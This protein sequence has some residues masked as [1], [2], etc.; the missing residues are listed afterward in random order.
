MVEFKNDKNMKTKIEYLVPLFAISLLP[1]GCRES[2]EEVDDVRFDVSTA[3]ATFKAGEPVRFSFRGNP[4]FIWFYSGERG[5]EYAFKEQDRIVETRMTFSFTTT[6]ASGTKGYPNPARV[7]ISYSTDFSGEYTEEAVREAT[8]IDITDRFDMPTDIGATDLLSGEVNISDFYPDNDTPLYLSFHYV[9]EAYDATAAGGN[10]NGRT[11][12]NF[13]SPKINGI[14]GE[15]SA[16]LYDI[17]SSNWTIVRAA[18][19]EGATSLPDIN[20]SRILLRSEFQP[21]VSRECWAVA[22][23]IHKMDYINEGPDM[24]VGIKAMAEAALTGYSYVYTEPGEYTA[25]FVAANSNVY[26]RRE[27]VR[28]VKIRIVEDEGSIT[29]PEAGE[30]NE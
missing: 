1:C 26:E 7:P 23:P 5:N 10:G 4:D 14:A 6:T 19:F 18:S 9:V 29:P 8:W 28:S 27:L 21:P 13:K 17:A 2:F 11:Q 20:S 3:S 22:G 25:T 15:S 24:G 12:W 16:V 30:W